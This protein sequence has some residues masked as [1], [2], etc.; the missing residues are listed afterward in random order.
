MNTLRNVLEDI[1]IFNSIANEVK[2]RNHDGDWDG[3]FS[4]NGVKRIIHAIFNNGITNEGVN[5]LIEYKE[6]DRE[7][8]YVLIDKY[9]DTVMPELHIYSSNIDIEYQ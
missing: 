5:L 2:D 9:K 3:T 4:F 1:R 6:E 8:L 7:F